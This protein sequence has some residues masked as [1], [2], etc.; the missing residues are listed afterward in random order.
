M[1]LA[2]DERI[3]KLNEKIQTEKDPAKMTALVQEL[4]RQSGCDIS[5]QCYRSSGISVVQRACM[6][7][8]GR[9]GISGSLAVK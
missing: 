1:D 4:L 8:G 3:C 2:N 9:E 6:R 7:L 5:A